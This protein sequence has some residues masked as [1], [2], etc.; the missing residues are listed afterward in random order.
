M[1][2][3]RRRPIDILTPDDVQALIAT[4]SNRAPSGI[5]NRALIAVLYFSGI[6]LAEALALLPR[7]IDLKTGEINV[8]YGKGGRQRVVGINAHAQAHVSRWMDARVR[9]GI[10]G[11]QPVFCT[12]SKANGE[13]RVKTLSPRYVQLMLHRLA[14]R[15]PL[16][17]RIHPHGLRH[18]HA[19]HLLRRGVPLPHIQRQL[20]HRNLATTDEYL[21]GLGAGEH[22]AGVRDL[23][24]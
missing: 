13:P 22:V 24:W 18:S 2:R 12:F 3:Q 1:S 6:R 19:V 5:R 20:G 14:G 4:A 11:R 17:K 10:N 21:R 23:D 15:T 16:Q 8:R 9:L 7:D